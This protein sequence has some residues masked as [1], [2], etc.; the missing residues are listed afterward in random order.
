MVLKNYHSF[1]G[2]MI[3][4]TPVSTSLLRIRNLFNDSVVKE[5]DPV[6]NNLK[7]IGNDAKN[8][9]LQSNKKSGST[10]QDIFFGM[11]MCNFILACSK[12]C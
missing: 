4:A 1:L 8:E 6:Y 2:K 10:T 11:S 12:M 7:L 5:I 9:C 3:S